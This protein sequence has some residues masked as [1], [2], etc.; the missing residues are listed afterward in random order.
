MIGMTTDYILKVELEKRR[1]KVTD[2]KYWLRLWNIHCVQ[3]FLFFF[4]SFSTKIRMSSTRTSWWLCIHHLC[5]GSSIQI[6]YT[7]M[8]HIFPFQSLH[9]LRSFPLF[10]PIPLISTMKTCRLTLQEVDNLDTPIRPPWSLMNY[11]WITAAPTLSPRKVVR[12]PLSARRRV[13][14]GL[15]RRVHKALRGYC[16]CKM[17]QMTEMWLPWRIAAGRNDHVTSQRNL[18]SLPKKTWR[19]FANQGF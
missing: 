4:F 15:I 18:L 6:Q 10:L 5:N 3:T 13:V 14:W 11:T 2:T 8:L 19:H 7:W 17:D 16:G 9:L 1:Q 12:S